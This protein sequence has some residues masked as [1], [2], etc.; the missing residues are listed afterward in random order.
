MLKLDELK[1]KTSTGGGY[2]PVDAIINPPPPPPPPKLAQ[3]IQARFE[4]Q[5]RERQEELTYKAED[6]ERWAANRERVV[7]KSTPKPKAVIVPEFESHFE[8]SSIGIENEL[9]GLVVA[10]PSHASQKFGYVHDAEGRPLFMLTKDMNQGA[11]TNPMGITDVKG[12]DNWQTHTIELVTY[13]SEIRDKNAINSRK[14]SMLWLAE[15]LTKHIYQS[16]HKALSNLV[17]EDGRF[18]LAISNPNHVI[19]AGYGASIEAQGQTIGMMQ[20]GQQASMGVS[21][22]DF[23]TGSSEE[24]K[25]LESA[26]WYQAGLRQKFAATAEA[27][28]VTL[29]D[30]DMAQN[31]FAY[32]TSIYSNTASLAIEYGIPIDGWDP[33][34]E[35]IRPSAEGLTDPTVKN[36]WKILPRTKPKQMLELLSS[37]DSSYVRKQILAS[38]KASHSESLAKNVFAYFQDG[39]EVAGHGINNATTGRSSNPEPAIVFEFRTIP[40]DL[41]EFVP[42]KECAKLNV[43]ALDEFVPADRR[44]ITTEVNTI[45]QSSDDFDSWFQA[46]KE[47]KNQPR[48][49]NPKTA[50]SINQKAEWVMTQKPA[51]WDRITSPFSSKK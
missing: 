32:L 24:L 4:R 45:V 40:S 30:Q 6:E 36:A 20:S 26:T 51:E 25:L 49:K 23:G 17:S 34:E 12:T 14:E 8:T 43:Q 33:S 47:A 5:R 50:A 48:V 2:K 41:T 37:H 22:K 35:G 15:V 7:R 10:L 42:R 3:T 38:L 16:N 9:K 46:Q 11:Y 29:N 31:V 13:P 18:T 21:A 27:G 44:K 1:S 19:A 28:N 39:G